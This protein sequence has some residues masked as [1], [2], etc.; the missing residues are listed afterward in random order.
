M[1]GFTVKKAFF[2]LWDNF[3]PAVLGNLGFIFILIL[4]LT[5]P[6][7]V[8]PTSV[9]LAYL[10]LALGVVVVFLYSGAAAAFA[11]DLVS[12]KS[13]EW[14]AVPG[15]LRRTWRISLPFA[16]ATMVIWLLL[17]IAVPTY[18]GMGTFVGSA[19]MALILWSGILWL[20]SSHYILPAALQTDCG[21]A[22]AVK[23]AFLLFFDNTGFTIVLLLGSLVILAVSVFT[24]FLFPGVVGLLVWH[25]TALKLRML[26]YDYLEENP[27]TPRTE[28]PWDALLEEERELVGKRTFKGLI[29]PWKE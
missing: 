7:E 1:I 9:P 17:A 13:L 24:V 27:E 19:A 20:L 4:P 2:D 25:Q 28:I 5:L 8:A 15:Y 23:K 21:F 12:Q 6:F 14:S 10:F 26:K 29:F 11:L 3:L 22:K 18:A 16:V